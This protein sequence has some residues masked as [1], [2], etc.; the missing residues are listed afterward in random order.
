MRLHDGELKIFYKGEFDQQLD[1]AL[2]ECL[3]SFGYTRWASGYSAN[4]IRDL[5]FLKE[6][7]PKI[8]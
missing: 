7:L 6:E 3:E 1:K 4:D 8:D 2:E 5:A